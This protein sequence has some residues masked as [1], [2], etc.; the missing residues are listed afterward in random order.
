MWTPSWS[1]TVKIES[2]GKYPLLLNRFHDHLEKFLIK[3]IVSTTDRL[4]YLK[5]KFKGG[6]E[7][8]RLF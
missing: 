4:I 7:W 6:Y 8:I 1:D 5:Y 2:G 3:G